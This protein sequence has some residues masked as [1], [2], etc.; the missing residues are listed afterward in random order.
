MKNSFKYPGGKKK[1][2]S[3]RCLLCCRLFSIYGTNLYCIKFQLFD[4]YTEFN[5]EPDNKQRLPIN[6]Q[7]AQSPYTKTSDWGEPLPVH[8]SNP[9][10]F[11]SNTISFIWFLN[12]L[13][14][15][16][17]SGWGKTI[18]YNKHFKNSNCGNLGSTNWRV[19]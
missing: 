17:W 16:Q 7:M 15:G 2:T 14:I 11:I 5:Q 18:E 19:H 4:I 13:N 8:T 1:S 10:I 6:K 12:I 9:F 3:L